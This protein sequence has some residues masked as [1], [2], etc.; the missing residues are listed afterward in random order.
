MKILED[1]NDYIPTAISTESLVEVVVN[2]PLKEPVDGCKNFVEYMNSRFLHGSMGLVTEVGELED[3]KD[4][5]NLIEECGDIIWYLAITVDS[6]GIYFTDLNVE[7]KELTLREATSKLVCCAAEI[8]DKAKRAVFYGKPLEEDA[9]IDQ[10]G[11]L[12]NALSNVCR[13]GGADI[14]TAIDKVTRKLVGNKETGEKG[15]FENGFS[16]EEAYN[17]DLDAERNILES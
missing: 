3:F 1:L 4:E 2:R 13:H 10:L 15:R 12:V 11:P 7:V 16:Q 6:L 14:A 5:V 9:V 17:R 8:L